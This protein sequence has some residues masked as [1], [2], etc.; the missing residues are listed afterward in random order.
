M[1]FR[2]VEV[3]VNGIQ[4]IVF[5]ES[6]VHWRKVLRCDMTGET[7][8]EVTDWERVAERTTER[9]V[10][11]ESQSHEEMM[12]VVNRCKADRRYRFATHGDY[13][14]IRRKVPNVPANTVKNA[15]CQMLGVMIKRM[16]NE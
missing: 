6:G 9:G 12:K 14:N 1:K 10:I 3:E 5:V 11:G 16:E 15:I 2:N 4:N 8:K 7:L 13:L